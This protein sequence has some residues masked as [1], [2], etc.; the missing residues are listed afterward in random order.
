MLIARPDDCDGE[1]IECILGGLG[2]VGLTTAVGGPAGLMLIGNW[3]DTSP[4]GWGSA[5]GSVAGVAA[6]A[7]VLKL[8]EG[9][10]D[11]TTPVLIS[12]VAFTGTHAILTTIGSR[13]GAAIRD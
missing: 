11:D 9:L 10:D 6:G 5:V 1:D 7:G 4:S 2:F 12:V 8:L 13:I 3:A